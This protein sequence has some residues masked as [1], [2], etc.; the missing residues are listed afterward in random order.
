[1]GNTESVYEVE[2]DKKDI[3]EY[4]LKQLVKQS[5]VIEFPK[6]LRE[7]G[8]FCFEDCKKI[9]QIILNEGLVEIGFGA[10][11]NCI[12]L[13]ELVLPKSV[14][15]LHHN[16]FDSCIGLRKIF[17]NEGIE[18]IKS[19]AFHNTV[20]VNTF[21]IP[22]H[23]FKCKNMFTN[24]NSHYFSYEWRERVYGHD[25]RMV[26]KV[27]GTKLP[28]TILSEFEVNGKNDSFDH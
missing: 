22:A 12:G 21:S 14:K 9:K 23:G 25:N 26:L 15:V 18:T 5:K 1:M 28:R 10:F 19:G 8:S 2:A 6:S 3:Y 20:E 13:R 16:C 4:A 17:I 11:C 27:R 24:E 7:I